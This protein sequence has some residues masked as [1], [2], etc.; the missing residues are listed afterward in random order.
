MPPKPIQQLRNLTRYPKTRIQERSREINRPHKALKNA[1]LTFDCV[2]ADVTGTSGRDMLDAPVA[3]ETNPDVFAQLARRQLRKKIPALREAP[4]GHFDAH[5]RP[6]SGAILA[7]IDV[8]DAHIERLSDAIEKQLHPFAPAV[9]LLDTVVGS[10][11]RG[12]HCVLAEIGADMTRFPTARPRASW[13]GAV[14]RATT[15]RP[16]SADPARRAT[17]PSG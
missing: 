11:R 13:G 14:P 15:S 1:G 6:W 7:P 10:Q 4:A 17:A 16:A 8:L 3:G 2:A 9:K 5:H 12:A